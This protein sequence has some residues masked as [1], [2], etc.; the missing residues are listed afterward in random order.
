MLTS[1]GG[2]FNLVLG[3]ELELIITLWYTNQSQAKLF[4]FSFHKYLKTYKLD[5]LS[6]SGRKAE[7]R[8]G[9]REMQEG[10]E[11]GTYCVCI[12]DSLCC[13]AEANTPLWG[14]CTSIKMFKKKKK[15]RLRSVIV[16]QS[17]K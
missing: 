15:E 2:S 6:S 3:S 4:I 8:V 10:R 16:Q 17:D 12:A 5:P 9:G 13:R 7:I 14:N 11:M 1:S